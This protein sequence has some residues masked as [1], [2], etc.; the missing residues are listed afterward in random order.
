[1]A[2][3]HSF[4]VFCLGSFVKSSGLYV[5]GTQECISTIQWSIILVMT[6]K[7]ISLVAR[8]SLRKSRSV[9][10]SNTLLRI[11]NLISLLIF[12]PLCQHYNAGPFLIIFAAHT[13]VATIPIIPHFSLNINK[14]G[15]REGIKKKVF[16]KTIYI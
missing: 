16:T 15:S 5:E 8:Y 4:E 10:S 12:L 6:D 2:F 1:M 11:P 14:N 7:D 9:L 13:L 3:C